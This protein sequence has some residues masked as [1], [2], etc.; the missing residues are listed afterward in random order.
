VN[1][2]K[3]TDFKIMED[4]ITEKL[5]TFS[6]GTRPAMQILVGRDHE[7]LL[8]T[9]PRRVK[10][11]SRYHWRARRCVCR[12]QCLRALR[13]S[14]FMY[15]ALSMPRTPS[16]IRARPRSRRFGCGLYIHRICRAPLAHRGPERCHN[17]LRKASPRRH[18]LYNGLLLTLRDAAKVPGRK[19]VIV[20][21]RTG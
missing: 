10:S 16:P 6:E 21:E 8:P 5:A 20:F 1:G 2:L 13:H 3:P 15:A 11:A 18:G 17:R 14:N 9:A 7:A 12:H 4:G 19:V